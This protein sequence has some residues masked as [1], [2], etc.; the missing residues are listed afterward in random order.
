MDRKY[1][2]I[3]AAKKSFT[4]FGYKAT[5]MEQVAK[6]ANVGK[7]TIYTF[8]ENKELLFQEIILTMIREM[9]TEADAVIEPNAPVM[10]NAHHMLMKILE[11]REKHLLFAKLVQEE[12]ELRTPIVKK[13]LVTIEEEIVTHVAT[14]IQRAV[15]R[16][17]I[18]R[19][20]TK[21]V[22]YLLYKSYMALV[23][24]WEE[25]HDEP[26]AEEKILEL[27]NDTIFRGLIV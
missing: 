17:E 14:W 10:K 15:D 2:I 21:M 16:Q 3:E 5:T 18:R 12:K 1:E 4:L 27:F 19:C 25:T 23:F 9:K 13:M 20:D 24:H 6:I 7:G 8:F 22:A 26:L 11:F